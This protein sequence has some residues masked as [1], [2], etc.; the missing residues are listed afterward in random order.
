MTK[1][2]D[3]KF[4]EGNFRKGN[5]LTTSVDKIFDEGN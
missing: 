2:V 5:P 4:D 3:K 1:A